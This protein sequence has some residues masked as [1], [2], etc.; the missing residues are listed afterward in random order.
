MSFNKN[1]Y[2]L[3]IC[4]VFEDISKYKVNYTNITEDPQYSENNFTSIMK[5]KC[6]VILYVHTITLDVIG[7][8]IVQVVCLS[9]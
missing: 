4:L 9:L 8:N 5:A 2:T 1:K 6:P 7:K 3:K